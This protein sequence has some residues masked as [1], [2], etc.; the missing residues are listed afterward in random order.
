MSLLKYIFIMFAEAGCTNRTTS[1]NLFQ[2]QLHN[3]DF[4]RTAKGQAPANPPVPADF[5]VPLQQG[6]TYFVLKCR[7][8]AT[9]KNSSCRRSEAT[10]LLA[11]CPR[12]Y[13]GDTAHGKGCPD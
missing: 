2:N 11:V 4:L 10:A 8:P 6:H 7:E 1:E 12:G 3:R 13:S 9:D 5:P